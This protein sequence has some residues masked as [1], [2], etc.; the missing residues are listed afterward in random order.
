MSD[1][2][3]TSTKNALLIGEDYT[4]FD[5][6]LVLHINSVF[7]T[8][9]Q[10]GIG[11]DAGFQIT[12]A[13]ET[14]ST[15]LADEEGL[16]NVKTYMYLRVRLLFDPPGTAYLVTAVENQIRELEWR[17]NVTREDREWVDP[18]PD[19]IL[20]DIIDGGYF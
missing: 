17:M 11:P 15:F 8:L 14:W 2:I 16:N 1:S 19:P 9:L 6:A 12:G 3:L 5:D 20:E 4:A 13:T 18:D 10:L 7:S